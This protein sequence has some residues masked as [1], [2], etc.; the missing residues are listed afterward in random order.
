MSGSYATFL[1]MKTI[2][3]EMPTTFFDKLTED[4]QEKFNELIQ[5]AETLKPQPYLKQKPSFKKPETQKQSSFQ[6]RNIIFCLSMKKV[7]TSK[8]LKYIRYS[9]ALIRCLLKEAQRN[10]RK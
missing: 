10:E 2:I 7:F 5:A 8:K 9:F 4:E 1:K 3:K 6:P